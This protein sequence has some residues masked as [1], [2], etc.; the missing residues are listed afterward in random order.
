[1]TIEMRD[2]KELYQQ[3]SAPSKMDATAG[4]QQAKISLPTL[5]IRALGNQPPRLQ[6]F[7]AFGMAF[8]KHVFTE[9]PFAFC[10]QSA[11]RW[12][13]GSSTAHHGRYTVWRAGEIGV[14]AQSD[15]SRELYITL[16]PYVYACQ[17]V[18]GRVRLPLNLWLTR[19]WRSTLPLPLVSGW[20][21]FA[22]R[23]LL[24]C[25]ISFKRAVTLAV[26]KLLFCF[27]FIFLFCCFCC[28]S[29]SSS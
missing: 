1:M 12:V 28:C 20:M 26:V 19:S 8:D 3:Q 22:S 2:F 4:W 6:F 13:D 10:Q 23:T 21:A 7:A 5:H 24:V 11:A 16:R 14:I 18:G 27:L 25:S 17:R 15:F 9:F 29:S